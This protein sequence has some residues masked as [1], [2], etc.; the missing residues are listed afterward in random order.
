MREPQNA[1]FCSVSVSR[2][3]LKTVV[4]SNYNQST[5]DMETQFHLKALTHIYLY[6]AS[7]NSMTTLLR[8]VISIQR[9]PILYHKLPK[10]PFF[11]QGTVQL[12]IRSA[13]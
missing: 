13:Q 3:S 1:I 4:S 8:Y 10:S 2:H 9:T 11:L 5:A 7:K 6:L 12:F